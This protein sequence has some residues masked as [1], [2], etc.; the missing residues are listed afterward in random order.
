MGKMEKAENM[1]TLIQAG[2][3]ALGQ[4]MARQGRREQ[5]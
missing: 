3:K 1:V 5:W 2:I 4:V